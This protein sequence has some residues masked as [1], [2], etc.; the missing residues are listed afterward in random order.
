MSLLYATADQIGL[1]TGGGQVTYH[2]ALALSYLGDTK[3][4]DRNQLAGGFDPWGWDEVLKNKLVACPDF[5]L[6]HFYSG[7]FPASVKHLKDRGC[8]VTYTIAAHDRAASHRAHADLGLSFNYP[9]LTQ[10]GLWRKY[11]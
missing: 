5:G 3:V 6:A 2:E 9:H 1:P 10:E 11:V 8:K 4:V 7:S